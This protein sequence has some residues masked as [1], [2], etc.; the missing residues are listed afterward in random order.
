LTSLS[1]VI[2]ARNEEGNL[3]GCVHAVLAALDGL[4]AKCEILIVD[5]G[6]TDGTGALADQLAAEIPGVRVVH[7]PTGTGFARAYRRGLELAT[8]EYVGL[9]PGDNEI[10]PV[11]MRAIFEAVGT[12]EIVTPFTANQQDRPWL[13]RVLSR[14]F[15]GTVNTLFGLRLRYF[16]GPSVYP[17]ALV[18]RIPTTTRGYAFLAEMLIRALAAGHRAVEVPMFIQ[19]R[20][21]GSSGAVTARNVITSLKTVAL[22]L[23]DVK[24]RRRPLG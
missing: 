3:K 5:D 21:F 8:G 11:S 24:V 6:S 1:V 14:T 7:N 2:P 18:R 16:Q 17:T 20:Q 22:V 13:R 15:T 19:P 10:Q 9:I 23:W 12:A 4:F